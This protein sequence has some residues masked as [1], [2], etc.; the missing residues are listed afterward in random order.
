[1]VP[2]TSACK[3]DGLFYEIKSIKYKKKGSSNLLSDTPKG[4]SEMSQALNEV[5]ALAS[6]SVM[7]DNPFIV[8]Y[9]NVWMEE[10]NI[11]LA[12]NPR[13]P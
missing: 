13:M 1:M 11:Y 8:R 12:V 4:V 7:D 6:L 5:Q 3:L 9:Y 10:D 2:C